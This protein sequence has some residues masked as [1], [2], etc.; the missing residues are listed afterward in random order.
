VKWQREDKGSKGKEEGKR[1]R[2]SADGTGKY[3]PM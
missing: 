3:P 2:E 1:G